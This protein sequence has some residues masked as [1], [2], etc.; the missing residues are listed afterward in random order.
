MFNSVGSLLMN[1]ISY[2]KLIKRKVDRVQRAVENPIYAEKNY[3]PFTYSFNKTYVWIEDDGK[4]E[5]LR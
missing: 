5:N 3:N 1:I 4:N 2:L